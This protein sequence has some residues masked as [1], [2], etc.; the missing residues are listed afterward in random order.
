MLSNLLISFGKNKKYSDV[1][2]VADINPENL[3]WNLFEY[4]QLNTLR[5]YYINPF[6]LIA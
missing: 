2:F 1:S 4:L 5:S 3:P 6:R